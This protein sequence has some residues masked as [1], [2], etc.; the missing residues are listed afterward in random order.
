MRKDDIIGQKLFETC[1]LSEFYLNLVVKCTNED[2][3]PIQLARA[4]KQKLYEIVERYDRLLDANRQ[5]Q[6]LSLTLLDSNRHTRKIYQEANLSLTRTSTPSKTP[7]M[8]PSG[9][10]P[11]FVTNYQ[12]QQTP[13]QPLTPS[14][15]F[16]STPTTP[17][18]QQRNLASFQHRQNSFTPGRSFIYPHNSS[19]YQTSLKNKHSNNTSNSSSSANQQLY[20][21]S[22]N[23]T[24]KLLQ[25]YAFLYDEYDSADDEEE[26][27]EEEETYY[28]TTKHKYSKT[29]TSTSTGSLNCKLNYEAYS[30]TFNKLVNKTSS[31]SSTNNTVYHDETVDEYDEDVDVDE[32][33]D[34]EE[35][36]DEDFNNEL[37]ESQII[38]KSYSNLS[39][40]SGV[41]ADS[42]H[43]DYSSCLI[44]LGN[45]TLSN[46]GEQTTTTRK[47]KH[48]T[49]TNKTL[50]S[51]SNKT[52]DANEENKTIVSQDE[53]ET[54]CDETEETPSSKLIWGSITRLVEASTFNDLG[55]AKSSKSKFMSSTPINRPGSNSTSSSAANPTSDLVK[56]EINY[57]FNDNQNSIMIMDT[58]SQAQHDYLSCYSGSSSASSSTMS[59]LSSS[60][61]TSSTSIQNQAKTSTLID[62]RLSMSKELQFLNS[63]S[64]MNVSMLDNIQATNT[65]IDFDNMNS[66][67]LMFN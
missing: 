31:S 58:N 34:E 11:L 42:Y 66:S 13:T 57:D 43:S 21:S 6:Q 15:S 38:E 17:H 47:E 59:P 9:V 60:S 41:F 32:E 27:E 39:K 19:R 61:P 25:Q 30:N 8:T 37:N 49:K 14:S 55:G 28:A 63:N 4:Y 3:S 20:H 52:L 45:T 54:V 10:N 51:I 26:E 12:Q 40:D 7:T 46:N 44:G 22:L 33:E 56:T 16:A 1:K 62:E 24:N 65:H 36:E 29:P 67:I 35:D 18:Y 2:E 64:L 50:S 5:R 53:N 48:N 23:K